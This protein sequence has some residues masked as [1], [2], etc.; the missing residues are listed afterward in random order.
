VEAL[1]VWAVVAGALVVL[2]R[3]SRAWATG[4]LAVAL[5]AAT[6]AGHAIWASRTGAHERSRQAVAATTPA[7]APSQIDDGAYATSN[8]CRACHPSQYQ[9][10][11]RSFH[12]TMTQEANA[13]TVR[14]PF[15]GETLTDEDGRH[16]RLYRD[17][18]EIWVDISGVGKKRIAMVTG[19]HHMQ[20]FWLPGAAGNAQVEFPFTWLFDDQRWVPR[21]DVFLVG[22]EY[23][24]D[25][26]LWNRICI[27]CHVTRGQP[28][29]D[30]SGVPASRVAELG[31]AC[32]ACHGPAAAHVAANENPFRRASL[33][34]RSDGDPTIV[35]PS[36][37]D[38]K[39]AAE[40]CGQCHGVG[41]PP[42]NWLREGIALRPGSPLDGTKP[43]LRVATLATG[44]CR[45]Q[46]AADETFQ[47]TRWWRDGMVR[48]S[49]REYN[50][51]VESKCYQK[52]ALTC[53]SC[54]SMHDARPDKQV[55]REGDAA[56]TQCHPDHGAAHTHHTSVSCQDCHMPHT[57]Y[58]LLRAMRSHQITVPRAQETLTTGRMNACNG[59]HVD[60]TLSWAAAALEKLWRQQAPAIGGERATVSA[61]VLDLLRGDAGQRALAAWSLGWRR[62]QDASGTAWMAPLLIELLDDDYS[63]VRYNAARSL[64]TLSGFADLSYDYI[65]PQA[66]RWAA[67]SEARRRWSTGPKARPELLLDAE[68]RFQRG[69]LERLMAGRAEDDQMFLAE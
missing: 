17:G 39:R 58:G 66:S 51:L 63:A 30:A 9:S 62:A 20:A 55:S 46:V 4:V 44:P 26:A 16:Y 42:E 38:P 68:G 61:T 56:C 27:E 23:T 54:H 22:S 49:G 24:K 29:L 12:R 10:W 7:A 57:T 59:C 15:A 28:R 14:A 52:G 8:A 48:V 19:S 32:E 33:H 41:C 13:S 5:V 64:R 2:L 37:L 21:R 69:E 40:V 6:A 43:I 50:G 25:P 60:K 31:I 1:L 45:A 11:H 36:R 35:T 53:V 67:Q 34:G 65:A 18:E 47:T 3:R